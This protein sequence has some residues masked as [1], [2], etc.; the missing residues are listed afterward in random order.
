[1]TEFR[2]SLLALNEL[3]KNEYST[4]TELFNF[5][6]TVLQKK[7]PSIKSKEEFIKIIELELDAV[8]YLI[9]IADGN[10]VSYLLNIL[11]IFTFCG[12]DV[13]EID[14]C[15]FFPRIS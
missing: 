6:G 3:H 14:L 7:T 12:I 10:V 5:L 9:D 13:F 1:M 15:F 11:K 4:K 8:S 2:K